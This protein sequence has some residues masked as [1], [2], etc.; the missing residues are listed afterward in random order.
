MAPTTCTQKQ[1]CTRHG[2]IL[3]AQLKTVLY[4]DINLML[5]HC[6]T[7]VSGKILGASC[8]FKLFLQVERRVGKPR[9]KM[10]QPIFERAPV[11][12]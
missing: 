5:E 8:H 7:L 11:I 1:H 2:A 12:W 9:G 6:G 10:H 3:W 4:F